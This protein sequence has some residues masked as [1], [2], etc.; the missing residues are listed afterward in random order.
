MTLVATGYLYV[1]SRYS[2][3]KAREKIADAEKTGAGYAD[4]YY[5]PC[6]DYD[7]S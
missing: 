5:I 7:M 3:E 2:H 1:Q 6:S 4:L